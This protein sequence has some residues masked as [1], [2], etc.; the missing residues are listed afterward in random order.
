MPDLVVVADELPHTQDA[1][2][3]PGKLLRR[4]IRARYADL[5]ERL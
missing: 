5:L 1:S 3:G 2:G 4:E